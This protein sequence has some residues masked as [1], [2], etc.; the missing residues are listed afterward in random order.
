[1]A[2]QISI[3]TDNGV[4]LSYHHIAAINAEVNQ[5]VTLLV[6]S[7]IDQESRQY[8]KDYAM[9]KIQGEPTFPYTDAKYISIGWDE[10]GPIINGGELAV[11]AYHWLK[12]QPEYAGAIDV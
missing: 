11:N 5:R 1:M 3:K 12:M 10:A 9:G 7:Y 8:D 4:V 6:R 2:I